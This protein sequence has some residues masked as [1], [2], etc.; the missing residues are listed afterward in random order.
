MRGVLGFGPSELPRSLAAALRD[1]TSPK[2]AVRRSAARELGTHVNS[3]ARREVVQRLLETARA[4][5]DNEVRVQAM[6]ALADGGASESV[7]DLTGL[8]TS[9]IPR[10]RQ[11][12]L[13][14]LAELAQAGDVEVAGA[15][16]SAIGSE[17]PALRYQGLVALRHVARRESIPAL[18]GALVDAD[19]EVRWVAVRL[20]DELASE[21]MEM[22]GEGV[23]QAPWVLD[24][25]PRIRGVQ[26]DP[27]QRVATAARL[28]LAS[29][30]DA[31]SLRELVT[32]LG[33]RLALPNA[34]DELAAIRVLA[35]WRVD[36]ARP[37]LSRRAW[38]L[39]FDGVVAFEARVALAALGDLRAQQSLLSD[40][41]SG[42]TA[43]CARAIE[44]VGRLRLTKG[45]AKLTQLLGNPG[46][47]DADAI[48]L[49]L[50]RLTE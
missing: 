8:A 44:P 13:L 41:H 4:D 43:R 38:P 21:A 15:A 6:L 10:V 22:E 47:L 17:F 34:E 42:V 36:Q 45:R 27:N 2:V 26:R 37:A 28:L 16:Q 3:G 30:G 7:G 31:E 40:L 1:V 46:G 33:A 29:L 39:F 23:T 12:A 48:R 11:M 9:A 14:A 25:I 24:L 49:A 20:L 18:S 35:R 5:P 32:M 19:A 50:K